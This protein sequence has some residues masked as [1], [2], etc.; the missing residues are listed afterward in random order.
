[1]IIF[2]GQP[3]GEFYVVGDR[4]YTVFDAPPL[5]SAFHGKFCCF[6]V[7]C[8]RWG[9]RRAESTSCCGKEDTILISCKKLKVMYQ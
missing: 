7:V 5:F 2:I 9:W 1:M 4:Y 6:A 8:P 3:A